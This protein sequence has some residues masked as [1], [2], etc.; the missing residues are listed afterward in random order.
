MTRCLVTTSNVTVTRRETQTREWCRTGKEMLRVGP[1]SL[2]ITGGSR[3]LGHRVGIDC[4]PFHLDCSLLE[5]QSAAPGSVVPFPRQEGS[6]DPHVS[7]K[8]LAAAFSPSGEYFALTDDNKR[9]VLFR[10]KPVWE[11]ISVRWVSRRC[12][13]LTFSPCGNHILVADK[14]GDVFS[15]S[16]P[17]ALEQGRLEL[18]HLSMLLDVTISLDGKH[19]ITCDRDEKIR[20]SCW[21]APHVIMSFCLGHTEFVSQLLPLPGQEKLLLSGSGRFAV[22]RISCCSC[23]GI[24]LAV[25]CEG[26]PGIF[27]FSVSPEPRLTF[28]QYIAL[29][30]TPID[31]DF[32]GSAFLWVLSGVGEEPLLKYKELDGQWQS[33][34][35]DEEL[36]RLTG[37]IQENWGDLEGAGAPESRFVGLYKAVFDNMATY[38]QKKELRLESEKRKAADGQVVLASKVQKTES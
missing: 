31:L 4:C 34:S 23:N 13:A 26:V 18:G 14:S 3:L 15:F 8:I 24:Q 12:T 28:T 30:H 5:K 17:R 25:L 29:T 7:D 37:I 9:L 27:L 11:K 10:T 38:L 36:T 33:V 20:V 32:D 1:G 22:S 6:A 16:V 35:N 19:I 2:A 21:G